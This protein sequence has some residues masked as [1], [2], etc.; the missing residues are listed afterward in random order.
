MIFTASDLAGTLPLK[1]TMV[2]INHHQES[3]NRPMGL[4][5]FQWFFCVKGKGEFVSDHQCSI[6][7]AGQGLLIYPN[8]P[9]FYRSLTE[10]WTVHFIG[11][12]GPICPELL[13]SLSMKSSGVYHLSQP[14]IFENAM[15]TFHRILRTGKAQRDMDFSSA[16]YRFLLELSETI[17]YIHPSELVRE[18]PILRMILSYL[19][20]N[21][22]RPVSLSD[23]SAF[24]QHSKEYLCSLFKKEMDQTIMQYLI[25]LRIQHA[26]IYLIQYPEKKISEIAAMCGFESPSYFGSVFRKASG[27]TPDQYRKSC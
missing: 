25:A 26:K 6:V 14:D 18:N 5:V 23:L 7:T 20:Q 3:I 4:P 11:F 19:E 2:G 16:C 1:L 13:Q 17:K 21:Y 15:K 12:D 9:H 24:T 10:D 8:V 27:T 22:S